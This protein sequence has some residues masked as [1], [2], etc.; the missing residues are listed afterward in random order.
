MEGG[1]LHNKLKRR[2]RNA[3]MLSDGEW[4]NHKDHGG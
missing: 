1:I 3:N 2:N 4:M